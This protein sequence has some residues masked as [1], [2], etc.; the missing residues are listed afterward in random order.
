MAV[1]RCTQTVK[2]RAA[3]QRCDDSDEMDMDHTDACSD[4]SD[5]KASLANWAIEFG[6][7][8]MA[9]SVLL[10]IL[11]RH[12]PFLPKDGRTLLKTKTT[13]NIE[14]LAVLEY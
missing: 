13:Y 14:T 1:K 8:L 6:I 7:S 12:H 2:K 10:S 9:L 3:Q 5:L 11:K 4:S